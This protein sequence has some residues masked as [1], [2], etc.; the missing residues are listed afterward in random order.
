MGGLKR[1]RI[2][3]VYIFIGREKVQLPVACDSIDIF[4]KSTLC[5]VQGLHHQIIDTITTCCS[6]NKMGRG[7]LYLLSYITA[8]LL[9]IQGFTPTVI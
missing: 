9:P 2:T 5:A 7:T 3:A 1:T 8:P 6:S 4:S